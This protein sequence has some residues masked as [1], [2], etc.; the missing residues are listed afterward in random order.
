MPVYK[1]EMRWEKYLKITFIM[2]DE[3]LKIIL[4]IYIN[5]VLTQW[6]LSQSLLIT[7]VRIIIKRIYRQ[8]ILA[9]FS[10]P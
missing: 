8:I 4:S 5:N 7:N 3:I 6:S 1:F 10:T 9:A 2:I